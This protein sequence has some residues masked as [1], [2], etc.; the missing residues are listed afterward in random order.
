MT[1]RASRFARVSN[2]LTAKLHRIFARAVREEAE[3]RG[4]SYRVGPFKITQIRKPDMEGWFEVA[5]WL[6]QRALEYE[7]RAN[8]KKEPRF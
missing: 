1:K 7:N 2:R 8:Q 3:A 6:E 5:D 4:G